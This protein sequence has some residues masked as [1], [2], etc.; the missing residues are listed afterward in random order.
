MDVY[1]WIF[2]RLYEGKEIAPELRPFIAEQ[3]HTTMTDEIS[4]K[5]I[6]ERWTDWFEKLPEPTPEQ[7]EEG[8]KDA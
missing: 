3:I 6:E 4:L 8:K 5:A 7:W 1:L 2:K